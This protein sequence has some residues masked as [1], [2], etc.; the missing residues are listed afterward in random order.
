MTYFPRLYPRRCR[1]ENQ[2]EGVWCCDGYKETWGGEEDCSFW[3]GKALEISLHS[4]RHTQGDVMPAFQWGI[5]KYTLSNALKYYTVHWNFFFLIM[6]V[7]QGELWDLNEEGIKGFL[8]LTLRKKQEVTRMMKHARDCYA[9]VLT[10][11]SMDFQND[12]DGYDSD[13]ELSDEFYELSSEKWALS[14]FC[15]RVSF[16]FCILFIFSPTLT[17]QPYFWYRRGSEMLLW[18]ATTVKSTWRKHCLCVRYA[19]IIV[20][21]ISTCDITTIMNVINLSNCFSNSNLLF[22]VEQNCA[23][24]FAGRCK[25]V[26]CNNNNKHNSTNVICCGKSEFSDSFTLT[27]KPIFFLKLDSCIISCYKW[28]LK[29][30]LTGLYQLLLMCSEST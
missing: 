9:K 11:T 5:E 8:S 26:H 30:S 25:Y 16:L 1:F 4:C 13:S 22:M 21:I 17:M 18:G 12:W 6:F 29:A 2:E 19:W 3:D 7:L 28:S 23:E 14:H 27:H 10:G 15:C 24:K 20:F